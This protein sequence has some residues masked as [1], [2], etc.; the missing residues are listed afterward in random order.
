MVEAEVWRGGGKRRSIFAHA[1]F[2]RAVARCIQGAASPQ[3]PKIIKRVFLAIISPNRTEVYTIAVGPRR[4]TIP[5]STRALLRHKIHQ[6]T[7]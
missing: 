7:P 1:Q 3:P 5:G 6:P 2:L 4:R